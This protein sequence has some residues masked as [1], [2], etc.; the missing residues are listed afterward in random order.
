MMKVKFWQELAGVVLM[1]A[2]CVQM[3]K[4]WEEFR[5]VRGAKGGLEGEAGGYK[6]L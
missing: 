1:L 4:T 2:A 5:A 6:V 3:P